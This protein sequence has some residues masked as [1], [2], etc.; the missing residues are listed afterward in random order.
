VT[1][2]AV[3]LS[4]TKADSADPVAPGDSF[5]YT[6]TVTNAG[7]D[8]ATGV[9]VTDPIPSE[10]T[11][12]AVASSGSGACIAAGNLVT[13][14]MDPLVVGVAWTITVTVDVPSDATPG[15]VTNTATV[16]GAGDT[17][18]S[19][20]AA[21]ETTT[22]GEVVGS[23]DLVVTK[24]V[25]DTSPHEGDTIEYTVTVTNNG[26]DR[27]TG[28]QVTDLLPAG[29]TFV[30]GSA[31][32]GSYDEPSGLW[33]V[34]SL[35]VGESAVLHIRATV[36]SGTAGTTITNRAS[37]SA[38]DQTDRDPGDDAA[39]A[40][41]DVASAGGTAFTGLPSAAPFAWMLAFAMLGL[42][43][44]GLGRGS[45]RRTASLVGPVEG[46]SGTSGHPGRFLAEPFFFFKE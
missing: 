14:S 30:S 21:S 41:A 15:T 35:A 20:D 6:V 8:D 46:T 29:L 18:P 40:S 44:L 24:T 11:V 2:L 43:A 39:S 17:D 33:D 36:N 25:D 19:N 26:S 37:V 3:D 7:P 34:G 5:T 22:I 4:I 42:A 27:A 12:T 13:C 1:P 23:A 38:A 9:V 16:A 10:L 28:V 45:R 31:T 32:Q